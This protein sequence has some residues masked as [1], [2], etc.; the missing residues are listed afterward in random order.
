[1]P[2]LTYD[3]DNFYIDGKKTRILSGAIHYF[4]VVPEYWEDRLKKLKAMGLNTVETYMCWNLHE[5]REGEF[6]FDGILDVSRFIGIAERLGLYVIVRP[7]PYICAE[8]DFGGLP[9]WLQAIPGLRYRCSDKV[10]LEKVRNY[11]KRVS[12]ELA[13]H[14]HK[15]GGN[16]IMIQVE[17]E[18]GSYGNDKIYLKAIEDM[19]RENG[20]DCQLFTSD[21]PCNTMVGGGSLD[22]LL[23]VAN[24]GSHGREAFEFLKTIRPNQPVMCGE[25]WNGWFDHWY[26]NHHTRSA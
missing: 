3:K 25:F 2:I 5:R 12:A 20:V 7:G 16:I 8:W 14:L 6:D 15:N 18:Y 9:A 17:N 26:E 11:I 13:P 4:R 22:G 10:Y 24:F 1:M 21:G 19:Y 23:E